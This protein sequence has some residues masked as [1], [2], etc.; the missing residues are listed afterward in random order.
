VEGAA[1][2][3]HPGLR[4]RVI[5][6]EGLI[7]VVGVDP[8]T[9]AFALP[10]LAPGTYEVQLWDGDALVGAQGGV[11]VTSGETAFVDL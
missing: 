4:V 1:P 9:G 6:A 2:T 3:G 5:G 8:L 10:A 7:A 11:Q